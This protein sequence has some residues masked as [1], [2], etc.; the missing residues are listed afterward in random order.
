MNSR[1]WP[2]E[3]HER[4]P[5][6]ISDSETPLSIR[7]AC[8]RLCYPVAPG[9]PTAQRGASYACDTGLEAADQAGGEKPNKIRQVPAPGL[10]P[11][12]QTPKDCG[13]PITPR[14]TESSTFDLRRSAAVTSKIPA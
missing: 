9:S 3:C 2:Y 8:L 4:A 14:R 12:Q 1:E 11:G 7:P 13:L 5:R 10:E 6:L